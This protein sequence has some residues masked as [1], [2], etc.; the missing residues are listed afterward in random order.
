MAWR[1]ISVPISSRLP[2]FEGDPPIVVERVAAMSAG[3]VCNVS[4]ADLGLHSGTHID[5][6]VHFIEGA[7]GIEGVPL[8][9][10]AGHAHVVDA[11]ALPGNIDAAAVASLDIPQGTRRLLFASRNSELWARPAFSRDFAAL[12]ADAAQALVA[13]GV[14]LVGIDYLSIAPFGD[15][16]P[17]HIAL[18]EAGVVIVEGLDLRGV[19]GGA[20]EMVCLPIL[21]PGAD[22][23][24]AR[25]L[26]REI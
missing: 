23:A 2:V 16:A 22:G 19:A 15:P 6:P 9:A 25:A 13:R 11:R 21:V 7:A 10:L 17:T 12:T 24:P 4:R 18:L 5:A 26:L 1:D 3:A 14:S 8:D 20:W